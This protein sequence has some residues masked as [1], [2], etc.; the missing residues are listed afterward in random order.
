MEKKENIVQI[1]K[2]LKKKSE[3]SMLGQFSRNTPFYIL[4]STVL[5]ARNK[6]EMTMKATRKLF[7]VYKTPK[8]I[9]EAP[10]KKL[11]PLIKQSGF[12]K[13]KAKRIKEISK[14]I[15]EKYKG[16]VPKTMDELVALPGVGRKTAGCVMVYAFDEPA[17][18]VDVHVHRISNRLGWVKTKTPEQTEQALM[19]LIPKKYWIDVNEILVIHG[20]TVCTPISPKCSECKI[21]KYCKRVGVKKSR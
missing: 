9:A 12:Y 21:R 14:I 4:I 5:S 11:E 16:K 15:F 18:P 19:K 8:Q 2:I 17:I 6:D 7:A 13:T 10:L 20:Q 3:V 1:I